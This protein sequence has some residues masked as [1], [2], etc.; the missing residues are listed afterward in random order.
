[1][2]KLKISL[3]VPVWNVEKYLPSCLESIIGQTYENWEAVLVDDGSSD[4][5]GRICDRIAEADN[6]FRVIHT[7]NRGCSAARNEGLKRVTGEVIGFAD[8]DD[9]LLPDAF[10]YIAD[11]FSSGEADAVFAG[12]RRI[13]E[14]GNVLEIRKGPES[15]GEG[16]SREAVRLTLRTGRNS[17]LGVLWNKYFTREC[18]LR[19]GSFPLFSPDYKVG[20]D[21]VWLLEACRNIRHLKTAAEPVYDY[22]IRRNSAVHT[23]RKTPGGSTEPEARQEMVVLTEAYYP[24]LAGLAREK[25]RTCLNAYMKKKLR[26]RNREAAAK[27]LP[28]ACRY[29]R[30]VMNSSITPRRKMRETVYQGLYC[31][32]KE[33]WNEQETGL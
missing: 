33:R 20:E 7:E 10:R 2:E 17:Y 5:S 23:S 13:D 6:R 32:L 15:D 8:A 22:R 27:A 29:Y 16:G 18:L 12:H 24:E 30:E 11:Q 19:G 4:G 25:Y 28:Y 3:V 1:M 14:E 9:R 26:E 31:I 21:Q